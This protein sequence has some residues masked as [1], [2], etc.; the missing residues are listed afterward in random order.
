MKKFEYKV[1]TI[2]TNMPISTKGYEKVA[3]EFEVQLNKLGAEGWEL[4]QRIDDLLFLK[5][6]IEDV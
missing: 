6:E 1:M 3:S 5:R 4:I 2:A